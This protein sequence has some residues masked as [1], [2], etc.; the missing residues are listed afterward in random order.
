MRSEV[1]RLLLVGRIYGIWVVD[2]VHYYNDDDN[3]DDDCESIC[4]YFIRNY[5]QMF[6]RSEVNRL[7]LVGGIYGIWVFDDV[8]YYNDDCN[9]DGNNDEDDDY[10]D[11]YI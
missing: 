4:D 1:N 10:K 3:D 9:D 8:H 11:H 5:Q 6:F 7:L 2:D